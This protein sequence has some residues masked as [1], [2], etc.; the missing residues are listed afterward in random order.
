MTPF[1]IWEK[2]IKAK[3]Y[4]REIVTMRVNTV[5]AVGQITPDEYTLLINLI[6]DVYSEVA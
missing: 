5:F 2:M 1:L 4:S 6:D 3:V